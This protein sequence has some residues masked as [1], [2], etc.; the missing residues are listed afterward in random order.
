MCWDVM[1]LILILGPKM[2]QISFPE[3]LSSC[4][5]HYYI[6]SKKEKNFFVQEKSI[7]TQTETVFKF[8]KYLKIKK[9]KLKR[10]L[11]E[12]HL[13]LIRDKKKMD[14]YVGKLD[15]ICNKMMSDKFG[16]VVDLEKLEL[17]VVNQQVEE[18]KQRMLENGNDHEKAM[19]D[20]L[21]KINNEKDEAVDVLKANT[22]RLNEM[23]DVMNETK[24]LETVLD[25]KQSSLVRNL[26][27]FETVLTFLTIDLKNYK[28]VKKW[29]ALLR[30]TLK[31]VNV[32][33]HSSNCK[34][35]K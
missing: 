23:V 10:N 31:N 26:T 28:R 16:K 34:H 25:N 12:H 35:K 1:C 22:T 5:T 20:W 6:E 18:L 7:L 8:I 14:E 3:K 19:Q 24:R 4:V 27:F 33:I 30:K 17:I 13:E 9:K 32:C 15:R 21:N 2:G 11:K 29:L